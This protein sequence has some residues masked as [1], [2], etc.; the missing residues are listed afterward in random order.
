MLALQVGIYG[1]YS[2]IEVLC[3]MILIWLH[4]LCSVFQINIIFQRVVFYYSLE[5]CIC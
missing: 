3:I 1:L 5:Y 2:G 4:R